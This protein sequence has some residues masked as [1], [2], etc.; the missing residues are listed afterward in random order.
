MLEKSERESWIDALK[1]AA[2]ILV[3]LG[4]VL[5]GA[6]GQ[7]LFI[8]DGWMEKTHTFIYM[9]HMP[10]F[11]LLSGAAF[12]KLLESREKVIS[13]GY[14]LRCLNLLLIYVFWS[15]VMYCSKKLFSTEASVVYVES[16]LYCLILAPVDPYWYLIVL[17]WYYMLFFA[18]RNT[19][20]NEKVMKILVV[21]CFLIIQLSM[22]GRA[23]YFVYRV[24]YHLV[25]FVSGILVEKHK[26]LLINDHSVFCKM[27]IPIMMLAVVVAVYYDGLLI[28]PFVRESLAFGVIF[29]LMLWFWR[30]SIRENQGILN[31]L[32]RNSLYIYLLHNYIT[33]LFRIVYKKLGGT[34]PSG[35]YVIL[36]LL[37]TLG[38]SCCVCIGVKRV[39]VLDIFFQ[40]VKTVAKIRKEDRGMNK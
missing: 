34:V 7:E 14:L 13:G 20:V 22:P 29:G 30:F 36:C 24:L 15:T 19:W 12:A 32:G 25:F 5:D 40:P 16:L 8:N 10:L 38:V 6:T 35:I 9:F 21:A 3:V 31:W 17:F 33:V 37:A 26:V 23:S 27:L 28:V 39:W 2:I 11:F 1:G 4:H 18:L